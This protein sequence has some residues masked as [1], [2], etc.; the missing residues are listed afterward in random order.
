MCV[1]VCRNTQSREL[2]TTTTTGAKQTL[3][4]IY[5]DQTFASSSSSSPKS[6]CSDDFYPSR[7]SSTSV[8]VG[9]RARAS[10]PNRSQWHDNLYGRTLSKSNLKRGLSDDVDDDDD[11]G[12]DDD[13]DA[14]EKNLT[15]V[16]S[17]L[18]KK[19][20]CTYVLHF[21][22]ICISTKN[23]CIFYTNLVQLLLWY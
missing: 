7:R 13:Y 17:L 21:Y 23:K 11:D 15:V 1:C 2:T 8:N 14:D 5:A 20:S 22:V 6:L 3:S 16:V 10:A 4:L 18:Q 9:R 19:K 12:N